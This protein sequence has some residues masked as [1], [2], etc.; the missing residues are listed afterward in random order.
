[1]FFLSHT[2]ACSRVNNSAI[3]LD[4]YNIS[5]SSYRNQQN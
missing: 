2:L 5:I 1:L 4:S 3:S